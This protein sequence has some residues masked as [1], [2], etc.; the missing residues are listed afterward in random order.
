M[1]QN[2]RCPKCQS[3]DIITNV[4]PLDETRNWERTIRL[5]CY[6]NP[7]RVLFKG[8]QSTTLT[9]CVC[10]GCGYVEFYAEDPKALKV[11]SG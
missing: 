10:A 4:R 8:A 9:A 3:S 6:R 2:N 11:R 1:R 5:E 7:E